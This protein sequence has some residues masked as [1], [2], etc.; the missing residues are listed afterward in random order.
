MATIHEHM[1]AR[2]QREWRAAGASPA[3]IRVAIR[4]G[5]D[6]CDIGVLR[7]FTAAR[8]LL[9]VVRCPKAS[10]VVWHGMLPAK[11]WATK[12]KTGSSGVVARDA[13]ENIDPK[14][15]GDAQP[16]R[17]MVSD[18][19]L[20]SVWR[21]SSGGWKKIFVSAAGGAARGPFTPQ[22]TL[23][24]RQLNGQL[25]TRIQH[26]CQDDWHSPQNPGIKASDRFAAFV[27]GKPEFLEGRAACARLYGRYGLAWP[28]G[29]DGRHAAS[30]AVR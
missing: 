21:R 23:L 11:T 29:S 30:R 27:E 17:P 8:Q 10:A 14:E 18:Y 1:L 16:R 5:M 19:D 2:R 13:E 24:V 26:G 4:S 9:I 25:L 22:A 12:R 15:R 7:R 3:D 28:Y 6:A 20:M